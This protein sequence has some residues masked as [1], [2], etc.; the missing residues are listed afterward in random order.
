MGG[1]VDAAIIG[2]MGY[3]LVF[4]QI[5]KIDLC[6]ALPKMGLRQLAVMRMKMRTEIG[7]PGGPGEQIIDFARSF[8][9]ESALIGIR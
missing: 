7:K 3:I 8:S 5:Y 9:R 1:T 2:Y 4:G 6:I